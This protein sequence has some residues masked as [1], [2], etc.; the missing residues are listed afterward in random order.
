M[1]VASFSDIMRSQKWFW[2]MDSISSLMALCQNVGFALC[3]A[4]ENEVGSFSGP[5]S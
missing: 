3:I 2:A 4:G 5:M 1:T